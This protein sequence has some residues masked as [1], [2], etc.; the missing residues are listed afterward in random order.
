VLGQRGA[1]RRALAATLPAI[2]LVAPPPQTPAAAARDTVAAV[3]RQ[4]V[5]ERSL[6]ETLWNRFVTWLGDLME[7]MRATAAD[8]PAVY[9]ASIAV[10][11]TLVL[12]VVARAAYLAYARREWAEAGR[13]TGF[14]ATAHGDP[15]VLAQQL[16]AAGRFTEAAHALYAALLARL[17]QRERLRLHPSKTAGDYARELRARSSAAFGRFREFARA[18]DVVVYG[19]GFCDR[20]RYERLA[21]L[22]APLL[23]TPAGSSAVGAAGRGAVATAE[24]G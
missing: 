16:S 3:F 4:R 1:D 5:Y 12:A 24:R 2:A 23:G 17:A 15:W 19:L 6:R 7:R 9:W 10:L 22:A 8:S 11:A 20:E 13:R 14:G 18:Y 21:A